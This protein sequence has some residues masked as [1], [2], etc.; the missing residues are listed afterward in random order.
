MKNLRHL[1]RT[2]SAV[3]LLSSPLVASATTITQW[4]DCDCPDALKTTLASWDFEN[5]TLH[6]YVASA[7]ASYVHPD[8]YA[9]DM[10]GPAGVVAMNPAP[11]ATQWACFSGFPANGDQ[12]TVNFDLAY[13]CNDL[14]EL[15]GF[16]FD[17]FSEGNAGGLHGPTNFFV[18]ILV[19][20]NHVWQS[21][22]VSLIPGFE[23]QIHWDISNPDGD[24]FN[25]DGQSLTDGDF[26]WK[27]LN[28]GD[29]LAFQ[30][31][32]ADANSSTDGLRFD[33]V[34]VL[35]CV[36]EPSGALL[37]M[38]AGMVVLFRMRRSR[39]VTL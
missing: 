24:N 31:V 9:T 6:Q 3:A 8:V 7:P 26:S 30:I 27:S 36:P 33:N 11:G 17:V 34:A 5:M 4:P 20:D 18:N 23:N 14:I 2:L 19:N 28:M 1:S 13:N 39:Y 16:S 22:L 37:L 38:A 29:T 21:E 35:A 32:A 15:C 10:F 12:G 25:F